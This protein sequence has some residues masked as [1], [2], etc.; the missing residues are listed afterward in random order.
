MFQFQSSDRAIRGLETA[1]MADIVFLLLIFFLLSSSFI[2]PTQIPVNPPESD[3][4]VTAKEEPVVVTI[5]RAGEFYVG[6]EKVPF[7]DL[8]TALAARL[9]NSPVKSVVVRG[10]EETSLGRLVEVMDL[11]RKG[12]ADKLAIATEEKRSNR[13]R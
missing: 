1:A 3:S 12:G 6:T 2:L 10:D 5:T 11:A 7:A 9:R 4:A 13:R 8:G